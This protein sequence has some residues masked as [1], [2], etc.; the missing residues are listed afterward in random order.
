M[1]LFERFF[2]QG[3][4]ESVVGYLEVLAVTVL[5]VV[6]ACFIDPHDPLF[7]NT[8]FSYYIIVIAIVTLFYGFGAAVLSVLVFA[9]AMKI[10]YTTFSYQIL[11]VYILYAFVLGE[12]SFYWKRKI[13]QIEQTKEFLNEKLE[14]S[15]VNLFVIK[16]SH[17]QLEKS[18]VMKPMSIREILLRIKNIVT[19]EPESASEE[20]VRLLSREC[21]VD[22]GALYLLENGGY[23]KCAEVIGSRVDLSLDDPLVEKA[24]ETKEAVFLPSAKNETLYKAVLPVLNSKG[25]LRGLFLIKEISFLNL[26]KENMLTT[27]LFLS[28]YINSVEIAREYS[29]LSERFAKI[30]L[31]FMKDIDRLSAIFKNHNMQSS[32]VVLGIGNDKCN[33]LL[34]NKISGAIRGIDTLF[35][36][37]GKN[38]CDIVILL[39]LTTMLG[40]EEFS[41]RVKTLLKREFDIDEK[42]LK[43]EIFYLDRDFVKSLEEVQK[44]LS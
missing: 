27:T 10:F 26:N 24:L 13:K 35:F 6:A 41:N 21:F 7:L 3:Y 4:K 19:K 32:L 1:A 14:E 22:S 36:N 38:W 39:P 2:P 20:F 28:Y 34:L 18:Y 9:V 11:S 8:H 23:K 40:A 17:D 15:A 42:E 30:P 25:E 37:F 5:S 43:R 29:E 16:T 12:F 33:D 44:K 31:D